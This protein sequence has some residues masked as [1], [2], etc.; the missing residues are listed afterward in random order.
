MQGYNDDLVMSMAIACWVRDTALSNTH[1]DAEYSKAML[2][3]MKSSKR[4][5]N[6]NIKGMV[7][8]NSSSQKH[9]KEIEQMKEFFWLYKG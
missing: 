8:Y 1:R 7:G 6:T 3:A 5:L 2:N 4:E 9:A